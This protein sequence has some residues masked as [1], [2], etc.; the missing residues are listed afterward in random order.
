VL[1]MMLAGTDLDRTAGYAAMA[2]TLSLLVAGVTIALFFGGA[3]EQYGPINDV[4]DALTLFLLILP[5]LAIRA[6]VGDAAGPVFDAVSLLAVVGL[7][8]GGVGQILLVVGVIDLNTSFVTGGLGILPVL[9]WAI[10]LA[11][12]ALRSDALPDVLGWASCLMLA[13]VAVATVVASITSGAPVA[14]VSTGL[15]VS[16]EV[17][18][19]ALAWTL[20]SQA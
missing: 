20:L 14:I 10:G 11:V 1:D 16:L 7:L 6:L 5:V 9:A 19:A 17:W 18:L 12:V 4:F 8:V 3:G 2:A 15:F 13:F